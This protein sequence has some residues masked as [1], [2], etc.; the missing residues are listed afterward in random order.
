[1]ISITICSKPQQPSHRLFYVDGEFWREVHVGIFGKRIDFPACAAIA[2]AEVEFKK[3]EQAGAKNYALRLLAMR[4]YPSSQ[5][6]KSL[7]RRLVSEDTAEAVTEWC[8]QQ[9]YVS[10]EEWIKSFVRT[11]Q[12]RRVGPQRIKQKLFQKGISRA[13]AEAA[14]QG[15]SQKEQ[16]QHLLQTRYQKADLKIPKE[17]QKVIASLMRKGFE[18]D[19]IIEVLY[20]S[21]RFSE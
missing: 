15:C 20:A 6:T 13:K 21:R 9:G 14:V 12:A 7:Q 2:E 4:S 10:D 1:M 19:A 11:Q 17:K 16:I 5:L 3:R 18:Y 8:K